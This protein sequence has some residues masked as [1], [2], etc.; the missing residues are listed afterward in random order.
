MKRLLIILPVL[1]IVML[2]ACGPDRKQE[3][4]MDTP[5]SHYREGMKYISAE[6]WEKAFNEFNLAKSLDPDY[7]PAYEGMAYSYLGEGKLDS[8]LKYAEESTSRDGKYWQGYIA[9][10]KVFVAMNRHKKALKSFTRAHKL[11]ESSEIT[12]RN[13]GYAY[14]RLGEYEDAREWYTA[15]LNIKADDGETIAYINEMNEI[16]VAVAGMGKAARRIA[17][18]PTITRAD[19]AALFIDELSVEDLFKDEK[20]N[21]FVEYGAGDKPSRTVEIPDVESDF[22]AYSFVS[23]VVENGIID[24]FPDGKFYP[25]KN[26]TKADYALFISRVLIKVSDDPALATQYIGTPSPFK[27]VPASHFAFNAIMICTSRGILE[28]DISGEFGINETVPGR[29]AVMAI[30]KMKQFFK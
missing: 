14:Y 17:L 6:E 12:K 29:K 20:N 1:F 5:G 21:G 18:N 28:T 15:A 27:D 26:V 9:E 7:A 23:K 8:A 24:L 4:I 25:D 10:G 3:S 2:T 19:V 16:Q 13:V 30:K 22:W 11:N